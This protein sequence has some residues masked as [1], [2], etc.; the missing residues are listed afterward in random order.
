MRTRAYVDGFN[1]YYGALKD[2]P[3]KWLDLVEITRRLLPAG[4]VVDKLN[5]FTAVYPGCRTPRRRPGNTPTSE[6]SEHCPK[7]GCISGAFLPRRLGARSRT[8]PSP[9]NESRRRRRSRCPRAIILRPNPCNKAPQRLIGCAEMARRRVERKLPPLAGTRRR[10][11]PGHAPFAYFRRLTGHLPPHN[12][13]AFDWTW[14]RGRAIV[15]LGAA[16]PPRFPRPGLCGRQ[17]RVG[18]RRM[19]RESG[20]TDTR[21]DAAELEGLDRAG[22]KR[23]W[24]QTFG[25]AP[26]RALS[27]AAL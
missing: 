8:C 4:H 26:P 25:S 21:V 2:T 1:L 12:R 18:A 7:S 6:R 16:Q 3:F 19:S 5:Y 14:A 15:P 9:T 11:V 27:C 23:A 20:M 10:T 13:W 22:L 24:E 17:S